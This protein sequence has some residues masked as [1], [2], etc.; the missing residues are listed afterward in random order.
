[1][2][3]L[4]TAKPKMLLN[5][6]LDTSIFMKSSSSSSSFTNNNNSI[7]RIASCSVIPGNVINFDTNLSVYAQKN[8]NLITN[9]PTNCSELTDSDTWLKKYGLKSNKL[10]F[11]HILSMIGFKQTQGTHFFSLA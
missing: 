3:Q 6:S 4:P 11:H 5:S 9:Y 7:D 2:N 8:N 10:T 1:M